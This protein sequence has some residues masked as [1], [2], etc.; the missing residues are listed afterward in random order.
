MCKG[1]IKIVF[2][3][4]DLLIAY[5]TFLANIVFGLDAS[6]FN[7][8]HPLSREAPQRDEK[9]IHGLDPHSAGC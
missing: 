5:S 6:L 7:L 4:E 2:I 1:E 8:H 3:L 9:K